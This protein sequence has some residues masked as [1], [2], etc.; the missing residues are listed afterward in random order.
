MPPAAA[1]AAAVPAAVPIPV[2]SEPGPYWLCELDYTEVSMPRLGS[3]PR[4]L[5]LLE[6]CV[7]FCAGAFF[8]R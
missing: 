7:C 5:A 3:D 4:L 8:I 2:W 1:A 6:V